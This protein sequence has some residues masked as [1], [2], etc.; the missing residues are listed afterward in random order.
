MPIMLSKLKENYRINQ[1]SF[2]SWTSYTPDHLN[3]LSESLDLGGIKLTPEL[4][5]AIPSIWSYPLFFKFILLDSSEEIRGQDIYREI[6][7]EWR[8]LLALLALAKYLNLP[9]SVKKVQITSSVGNQIFIDFPQENISGT[10]WGNIGVILYKDK[11]IGM[12]SPLTLVCT[13]PNYKNVIDSEKVRWYKD[14]DAKLQDPIDKLGNKE[15]ALL[16]MYL[17]DLQ[18]EI[19][20]HAIGSN[21]DNA[22]VGLIE[23]FINEIGEVEEIKNI[24]Q[25]PLSNEFSAVF[26]ALLTSYS[27]IP[28]R[29]SDIGIKKNGKLYILY[30]ENMKEQLN[31]EVRIYGDYTLDQ[32]S[33]VREIIKESEDIELIDVDKLF[34]QK[35][36]K[37]DPDKI[38]LPG[39]Y[40]KNNFIIPLKEDIFKIFTPDEINDNL[41]IE[42]EGK[43][44]IVKFK[45]NFRENGLTFI[46]EKEYKR[47]RGDVI[48]Y[49][50]FPII[51]FWPFVAPNYPGYLFIS[52]YIMMISLISVE[53]PTYISEENKGGVKNTELKFDVFEVNEPPTYIKVKYNGDYAGFILVE[54]PET[55]QSQEKKEWIVSIDFGT[56]N[57]TAFYREGEEKEKITPQDL[58]KII[59][60]PT[61]EELITAHLF[62]YFVP[63]SHI[64]LPLVTA[65]R[66][67]DPNRIDE[68]PL[69]HGNI[70]VDVTEPDISGEVKLN[71]KWSEEPEDRKL[72][73]AW[74]NQFAF[75]IV[76][77]AVKNGVKEIKF[78]FAYPT[79]LKNEG[80][81]KRHFSGAIESLKKKV[82]KFIRIDDNIEWETESVASAKFYGVES[83]HGLLSIDIGGGTTDIS[84]WKKDKLIK[85]VSIR[86]AGR[87]IFIGKLFHT[88]F[89]AKIL[90][91]LSRGKSEWIDTFNRFRNNPKVLSLKLYN[92]LKENEDEIIKK[93]TSISGTDYFKIFRLILGIGLLSIVY[94]SSKLISDVYEGDE[95]SI[96]IG[97]NGSKIIYWLENGKDLIERAYKKF[98]KSKNINI[99]LQISN[100][101]KEEVGK[102]LLNEIQLQVDNEVEY[103]PYLTAL[104]VGSNGFNVSISNEFVEFIRTYIDGFINRRRIQSII[105]TNSIIEDAL[106]AWI[107]EV[108]RKYNDKTQIDEPIFFNFVK[109]LL[110][111]I[112]DYGVK[113]AEKEL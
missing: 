74:I 35:I 78:K 61:D 110:D 42:E 101:P 52:E 23:N 97:G 33:N 25:Q 106:K 98:L 28:P 22:I 18:E 91:E 40:N 46:K 89:G 17:K 49:D 48:L 57:T 50:K 63:N 99:D 39:T 19:R 107:A 108:L 47:E 56:D 15:K 62:N 13:S 96:R 69:L 79:A 100:E 53:P 45:I 1:P 104:E 16:V 95:L 72:I 81:Y 29:T 6:L 9:V 12:L 92:I 41:E 73:S 21:I 55:P 68:N 2:N 44:V 37:L 70:I 105:N 27:I 8:G 64:P 11:P 112:K 113:I 3:S 58:T 51:A 90:Q 80:D 85:Q 102:G 43:K 75:H 71:L 86:F 10:S 82:E 103:N 7:S 36:I 109:I 20:N 30:D 4:Y 54:Q 66:V 38:Q 31:R 34:T 26:K 87:D 83:F 94:Y 76:S 60:R 32:V 24:K 5:T 111:S 77:Q 88:K 14:K 84:L 59:S 65:Y 67:F 93:I